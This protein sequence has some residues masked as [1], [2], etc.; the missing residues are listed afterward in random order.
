[1]PK[2][3][4]FSAIIEKI[5]EKYLGKLEGFKPEFQQFWRYLPELYI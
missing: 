5:A 1:L 4:F 3:G 2:I